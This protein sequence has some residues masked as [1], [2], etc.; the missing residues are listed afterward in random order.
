[1]KKQLTLSVFG[2]LLS[3]ITANAQAPTCESIVPFWQ[4]N[5]TGQPQGTVYIPLHSRQ[6]DCCTDNVCT[7]IEVILDTGAAMI[8]MGFDIVNH[9][10][11]AIPS[12]SLRYQVN[13]G[14][15][16]PPGV[17]ICI[18]GVGPHYVTFCKPGNN[19]NAYYIRSIA[20]PTFPKPD[21]V[22][23]GC[24]TPLVLLGMKDTIGDS[25]TWNSIF[26][27]PP[28]AFNTWLSATLGDTVIYTPQ[29]SS[30]P[31]V[32]Y[33]VCG[34]PIATICGYVTVCD[35]V[36]VYNFDQL[37]PNASPQVGQFCVGG[38][39]VT[40]TG[41]ATGGIAPYSFIWRNSSLSTVSTTNIFSTYIG[42][43]YSLEIRDILYDATY[44]PSTPIPITAIAV[45]PPVVSAGPDQTLCV[46]ASV[47]LHG[48]VSNAVSGQWTGGLGTFTPHDTSLLAGYTPT[49]AEYAAGQVTL[50]LTSRF[51]GAGCSNVADQITLFFPPAP[52]V[53]VSDTQVNCFGSSGI[54]G[55]ITSGGAG[56]LTFSWS[57]G[58]TTSSIVAGE[59]TY[60]LT[61]VDTLGCTATDC[62]NI[63]SPAPLTITMSSTDVTSNGGNDGTASTIV[64]GGTGPYSYSWSPGNPTGN[65]TPTISGLAFGIYTVI[66]TDANGCII[67]SSVVVNEP[68]CNAFQ[69]SASSGNVT[70]FGGANG[71]ATATPINGV[72]PF[73]FQWNTNP[74][75]NNPVATNLNAGVY[76]VTVSDLSNGCVH[77]VNVTI[78]QPTQLSATT[79]QNNVTVIGGND[80]SATANPFD[81]AP[82]YTFLWS[83]GQTT[84]TINNLVAGTYSVTVT[85]FNGC[86][87]TNSVVINQPPCNNLTAAVY[88]N[89]VTC[90]GGSDGSASVNVLFSNSPLT[91]L[92]SNGATTPTIS[93]LPAGA[94]SVTVTDSLNCQTFVQFTIT[95]PSQLSVNVAASNITCFGYQNGTLELF[96]SGGTFPYT[97]VWSNG[98]A[99]QDQINLGAGTY[100]VTVTDANGCTASTSGI[101]TE[102]S[103]ILAMPTITNALCNGDN[104]GSID[105]QVSGGNGGYTYLWSN[106]QTTQDLSNLISGLYYVT[107]TDVN[108]CIESSPFTYYV[109]QPP[110]VTA[111]ATLD[112]PIPGSGQALVQIIPDGGN[113]IINYQVSYDNGST[114]QPVGSYSILLP[115]DSAY[116]IQVTDSLGCTLPLS[117]PVEIDPEVKILSVN[118]N[119]CVADNVTSIPVTVNVNGGNG[120]PISISTNG[121]ATYLA[122]GVNTVNLA[123]GN[124]YIIIARD[125]SNCI[126]LTDTIF[127]PNEIV[128]SG[129]V[130]SF[131]G[132]VNVTCFGANDGSIDL[133]AIGGFGTYTYAWSNTAV[134]QDITNLTAGTYSVVVT[135]TNACTDTIAFTLSE[136]SVLASSVVSTGSFNGFDVPCN[137]DSLGGINLTVT[138]GTTSYTYAW[139]N[140]ASTEDISTLPAGTY[141]VTITDANSCIT[142]QSITLTEPTALSIAA[143]VTPILCANDST[144]TI[145]I[146]TSGGVTNYSFAWSNGDLTEDLSNTPAGIYQL[147]V[148]DA[149]N[150]VAIFVDTLVQPTVLSVTGTATNLT[151]YEAG[152]GSINLTAGGGTT[153]YNFNWSNNATT[154]DVSSLEAGTYNVIVTDFNGCDDTLTFTITRPDLLMAQSTVI[155]NF[156]GY[157]IDCFGNSNGSVD[158]TVT[159]GTQ[160]Y[161]YLWSNGAA[162]EDISTLEAGIYSVLI[163]DTNLCTVTDTVTITQPDSLF[164]TATP[165]S[166][167]CNGAATG[168]IDIEVTGGVPGFDYIWTNGDTIQDIANIAAGTYQVIMTDSNGCVVVQSYTLI[169]P[170]PVVVADSVTNLLCFHDS[171]GSININTSGG[172]APYTYG[173]SNGA[174]TEDVDSISAGNYQVIVTDANNCVDTL[175]YVVTEPTLLTGTIASTTDLNG[176]DVSCTGSTNGGI[177]VQIIGGTTGYTYVWNTGAASEDLTNIGAG[178]YNVTATD[179]NG[180]RFDT[181]ITLIEPPALV[182]N[183]NHVNVPCNG[184]TTGSIDLT[185]N[186]G[187]TPYTYLWSNNATT[188]DIDT[189]GAGTYNVVITDA[190]GCIVDSAITI[191]ENSPIVAVASSSN[192]ICFSDASG[193]IQ[194]TITGAAPPYSILWSNGSTLED[195]TGL[196]AGIY[197][198][199]ITDSN[200]CAL[201]DTFIVAEPPQLT[202]SSSPLVYSSG[203]NVSAYQAA[204]GAI[205]VTATGGT[206]PLTYSWSNGQNTEDLNGISAG[207]YIVTVTD[208]NGCT[209][210]DSV[211]LR[212]PVGIDMPTG[213]SPNMDGKN[214]A[215]VIEGLDAFK[216]NKLEIYNRWGNL[217]YD[218]VNYN[219]Q[220][221]GTSNTGENLPDGTYFVILNVND[222][223]VILTGFVDLRRQ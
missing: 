180:C 87:T 199:L 112:C 90:N 119:P 111:T 114:F 99:V 15:Q 219:N 123:P 124:T 11:Q 19:P 59:G 73:N 146:T 86:T 75:Q 55:S 117:L 94:Y 17:P 156:N 103:L 31:F 97:Y 78:T 178:I 121:G 188:Q 41:S 113:S 47:I 184:F 27:G 22:R 207:T 83:N 172:V 165:V 204:D 56:L 131:I 177:D 217:V 179:A 3:L 205:D 46:G 130:A 151:C 139:S 60:C 48:S 195:Q 202:M 13:C 120:G 88:P 126:S 71:T 182:L 186:G 21:S 187:V 24:S 18:S 39:G 58:D 162:T 7:S 33:L 144:G 218:A 96:V 38:P 122:P 89:G 57:N 211:T 109:P 70:C 84:Q 167:L 169:Q 127:I 85:D 36:R 104:N 173:W 92:W 66:A 147:T 101:I 65:G 63:T 115:T 133:S 1:M 206:A 68:R 76:Q 125:S 191:E 9:S 212:E 30:V 35:T 98:L 2:F 216:D 40:F 14:P 62:G 79:T 6:G 159:G 213:F 29:N 135:D 170:T 221:R 214:D 220:W 43:S 16:T 93:N 91:Y 26:P 110:V 53:A 136:P 149:N 81:G 142:T 140:T 154:E 138:G 42:G 80:G 72:G 105:L 106:G 129:T 118:F 222:G 201:V 34:N 183:E 208:A 174:I 20:K 152:N 25:P 116:Q 100:N 23:V 141:S 200:N 150:C 181:T 128:L 143:T 185:I 164:I 10:N 8:E 161:T 190:N 189:L 223:Q 37:I 175:S 107:I 193:S 176:F 160:G 77:I 102:P 32:D 82:P 209:T 44:C 49:T 145:N 157:A 51:P 69:A 5:L 137:G 203:Y 168:S 95:E 210:S 134:T 196:S 12:G 192:L 4:V 215:F 50:T 158:L 45:P 108:G 155:T 54:L 171:T 61:V 194:M 52:Q 197:S 64:S 148:T 163:T 74:V 166:I 153:P 132:G 28:G 67:N 198:V